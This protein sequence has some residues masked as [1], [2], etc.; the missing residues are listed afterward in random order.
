MID[1]R[2]DNPLGTPVLSQFSCH[3]QSG[4][5]LQQQLIG[6]CLNCTCVSI[7]NNWYGSFS[8]QRMHDSF[9]YSAGTSGN[10]NHFIGKL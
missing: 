3:L 7:Y 6:K 4:M 9:P 5:P 2:L 8:S 10:Y 1:D